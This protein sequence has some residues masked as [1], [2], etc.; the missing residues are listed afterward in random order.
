MSNPDP[1]QPGVDVMPLARPTDPD[2]QEQ[3]SILKTLVVTV[4]HFFGGFERLFQGL[5]DQRNPVDITYPLAVLMATGVLMFLLRLGARRQITKLL[6]ENGPSAAKYQ[7]LFGV[8]S[9]P[10]EDTLNYAFVRAN[11]AEVQEVV[12]SMTEAL[13]R[14]RYCIATVCSI[15][16]SWWLQMALACSPSLS[17]TVP[18]A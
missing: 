4:Q 10:H 12:T 1:T 16:T 13:I 6:R 11:V 3:V 5:T 18:V 17:G 9:C 14:A 2:L 8:R 15:S 7:A